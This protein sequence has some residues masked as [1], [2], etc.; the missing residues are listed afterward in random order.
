MKI[1]ND[2][3]GEYADV[4]NS[5]YDLERFNDGD[6]SVVL[7]QGIA[8]SLNDK[9]KLKHKNSKR[10]IYLNL[11]AP[12]AFCGTDTSIS[13]QDYFDDVYTLCPYT[14]K[15]L[16]GSKHTK[17]NYIP[18]PFPFRFSRMEKFSNPDLDKKEL[19]VIYMGTII[20]T[21]HSEIIKLMKSFNYAHCSLQD[22]PPPWTPTH[23]KVS[24]DEKWKVLSNAKTNIVINRCPVFTRHKE[25]IKGYDEWEN[26][27]AFK[28]LDGGY[29]PQFKPR[30]IEAMVCKT[31]NLVQ[32]DK[33]NVIEEW[34]T[35]G[36]HFIYWDTL[37]DLYHLINEVKVN[38]SKY[39]PII[40]SARNKVMEYEI[41]NMMDKIINKSPIK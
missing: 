7:F 26:S 14:T 34:F 37:E 6:D 5:F 21:E 17:A 12:C 29:V 8:T 32:R 36:E 24:S 38:F 16:N 13:S 31:L 20:H 4:I 23:V 40:E 22:F 1:V 9:L 25:W 28:D 41:D 10:K 3:S 39:K 19:D 2:T 30:V 33:W 18:I 15:W 11:E 27:E 35:P